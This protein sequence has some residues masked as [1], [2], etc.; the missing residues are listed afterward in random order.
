MSTDADETKTFHSKLGTFLFSL[1]TNGVFPT[2]LSPIFVLSLI[3][4]K[5]SFSFSANYSFLSIEGAHILRTIKKKIKT[6]LTAFR[7]LDYRK[8]I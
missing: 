7:L 3:S 5:S 8:H 4:L 6:Y 2:L 1:A